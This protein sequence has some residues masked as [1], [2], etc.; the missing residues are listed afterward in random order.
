MTAW[1]VDATTPGFMHPDE[2]PDEEPGE[3]EP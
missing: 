1:H 3:E 2:E